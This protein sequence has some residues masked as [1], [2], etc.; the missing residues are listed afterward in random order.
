MTSFLKTLIFSLMTTA[1]LSV[2]AFFAPPQ[3][4]GLSIEEYLKMVNKEK[5]V[6]VYFNADWCVPCIKLKPFIEQLQ[7]ERK[8]IELI[9]LDVDDNP[10]VAL[11]LEI[12]ALPLF[13][14]YQKGKKVWEN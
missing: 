13:I 14:V 8:E 1:A 2:S 3:P 4:T 9:P 6:M 12:N 11:Y 5:T 7:N 10:K